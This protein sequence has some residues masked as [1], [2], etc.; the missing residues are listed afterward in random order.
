MEHEIEPFSEEK[1]IENENGKNRDF[2]ADNPV[3]ET[4]EVY[5]FLLSFY[6]LG[7]DTIAEKRNAVCRQDR[8]PFLK[9]SPN[10]I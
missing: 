6:D 3:Y 7:E 8:K 4:I 10:V 9:D 5:I 2:C 1:Q